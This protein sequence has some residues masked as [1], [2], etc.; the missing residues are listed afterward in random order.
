[1]DLNLFSDTQ[2]KNV[3]PVILTGPLQ[4]QNLF[5]GP[6]QARCDRPVTETAG[7]HIL[8]HILQYFYHKK[9]NIFK[10]FFSS[11]IKL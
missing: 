9:P 8:Q 7:G 10:Y 2:V 11:K 6:L 1:M 4:A 3:G 5:M